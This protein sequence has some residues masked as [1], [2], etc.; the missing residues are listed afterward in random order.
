[1]DKSYALQHNIFLI[2]LIK[3]IP[4]QGF[5]GNPTGS[6]PVT[7]FVY[8]PFAPF[9]C[10]PQ[11]TR[12]FI[13]EI[14]QFFIMINFPWM[15]SKFT[16]IKLKFDVSTI[17]FE[18]PEQTTE[19][20]VGPAETFSF[21]QLNNYQF[22]TVE[23]IPDEREPKLPT[24]NSKKKDEVQEAVQEATVPSNE[25]LPPSETPFEIKM[26]VTAPFF[27]VCKQK[28]SKNVFG[29]LKR[30]KKKP[31]NLNVVPTRPPSCF[32]SSTNFLDCFLKKKGQ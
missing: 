17:I 20:I 22:P 3:A 10:A 28:K 9:G 31:S 13:A 11:L 29:F 4:L 21:A 8:I 2:S 1:M 25:F 30:R 26:I 6:G 27:H 14:P 16:T 32:T 23:E 5:D 24:I 19:K 15:K 18:N 7:H 12:L